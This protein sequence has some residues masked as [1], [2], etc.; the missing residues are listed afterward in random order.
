[1][2]NVLY[3][4]SATGSTLLQL[5]DLTDSLLWPYCDIF[6]GNLSTY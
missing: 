3:T 5:P 2:Q 6:L 1:M 4:D